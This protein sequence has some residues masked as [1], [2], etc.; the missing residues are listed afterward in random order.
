M[1]NVKAIAAYEQA[2]LDDPGFIQDTYRGDDL[3]FAFLEPFDRSAHANIHTVKIFSTTQSP[4]GR[5]H[6]VVYPVPETHNVD[7]L[8]HSTLML[9]LPALRLAEKHIKRG[10]EVAWRDDIFHRIILEGKLLLGGEQITVFD[11]HWLDIHHLTNSDL[12]PGAHR[13]YKWMIG[14]RSELT[15]WSREIPAAK[16]AC[17]QP[18]PY[19]RSP[20]H[21]VMIA[22][23]HHLVLEH[24]YIFSLQLEDLVMVRQLNED[25]TYSEINF[26][27]NMLLDRLTTIQFPYM[28]AKVAIVPKDLREITPYL[29][30]ASLRDRM[31]YDDVKQYTYDVRSSDGARD[32]DLNSSQPIKAIHWVV[33]LPRGG[34]HPAQNPIDT[35]GIQVKNLL[36]EEEHPFYFE[37]VEPWI[38][39]CNVEET[40]PTLGQMHFTVN[41]RDWDDL[42]GGMLTI[43]NTTLKFTFRDIPEPLAFTIRVFVVTMCSYHYQDGKIVVSS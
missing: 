29:E 10:I 21:A 12:R 24:E 38:A 42:G 36:R 7:F 5:T 33:E 9:D 35:V 18:W 34:G 37:A 32:V 2:R 11:H 40:I 4:M 6:R 22:N 1:N 20:K 27:E 19:S 41:P 13:H 3:T 8:C 26:R 16:L 25:G 17:P 43:P 39:G 15:S 30:R 14:N 23:T 31:Y 28:T